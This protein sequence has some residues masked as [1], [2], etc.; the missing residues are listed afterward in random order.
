MATKKTSKKTPVKAKAKKTAAAKTETKTTVKRVVT[1]SVAAKSE[2]TKLDFN[3]KRIPIILDSCSYSK[4]PISDDAEQYIFNEISNQITND[5]WISININ[6][7]LKNCIKA[8]RYFKIKKPE[9]VIDILNKIPIKESFT[10]EIRT[11]L[12]ILLDN[13]ESLKEEQTLSRD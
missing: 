13:T 12:I 8:L 7:F 3:I 5:S 10:D 11:C 9:S 6:G 1:E 2:R 4:I